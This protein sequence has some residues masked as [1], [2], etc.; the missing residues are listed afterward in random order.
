MFVRMTR[1]IIF[2]DNCYLNSPLLRQLEM[3]YLFVCISLA[4]RRKICMHGKY[5]GAKYSLFLNSTVFGRLVLQY[6]IIFF[7]SHFFVGQDFICTKHKRHGFS[8]SSD[9]C[10]IF[11]CRTTQISSEEND[12]LLLK[13]IHGKHTC[14]YAASFLLVSVDAH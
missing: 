5:T 13:S 2:V 12:N 4:L 7:H 14:K 11:S 3:Q 1:T 6:P 9:Y 10:S 8:K